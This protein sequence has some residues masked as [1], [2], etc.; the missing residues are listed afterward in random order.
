MNV[1]EGSR[2]MRTA[3]RNVVMIAFCIVLLLF[4]LAI[5]DVLYGPHSGNINWVMM[6][7]EEAMS[8]ATMT[9][10]VGVALWI[11]VWIVKGF[12]QN[13]NL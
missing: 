13:D 3:G 6:M 12:S 4:C 2:R 5:V 10:F 8:V 1:E 7:L 11:A 9:M